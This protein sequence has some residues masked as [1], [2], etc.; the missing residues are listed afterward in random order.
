VV[1][2]QIQFRVNRTTVPQSSAACAF[3]LPASSA[4]PFA[5]FPHVKSVAIVVVFQIVS[6]RRGL[7]ATPAVAGSEVMVDASGPESLARH[8][9]GPGEGTP[10]AIRMAACA[11]SGRPVPEVG[12]FN[13]TGFEARARAFG[14][15]GM[16]RRN[17]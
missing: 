6:R 9:G 7:A 13:G 4:S 10:A 3:F 17:F 14:L 8:T 15:A 2:G 1:S 16:R 11:G 12:F 5:L